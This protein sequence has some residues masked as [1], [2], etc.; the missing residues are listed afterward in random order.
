MN[1][2]M[3]LFL[4]TLHDARRP[5]SGTWLRRSGDGESEGPAGPEEFPVAEEPPP[6]GM[7]TV[8]RFQKAGP[9]VSRPSASREASFRA[10]AGRT[11]IP[12]GDPLSAAIQVEGPESSATDVNGDEGISVRSVNRGSELETGQPGHPGPSKKTAANVNSE[13]EVPR[14]AQSSE[15][16]D[17]VSFRET[18]KSRI[19]DGSER[20]VSQTGE[21]FPASRPS[22]RGASPSDSFVDAS[23]NP[24]AGVTTAR[25]AAP[26]SPR[27]LSTAAA[28]AGMGAEPGANAGPNAGPN[29]GTV[30]RVE[31][32]SPDAMLPPNPR[33]IP[34]PTPYGAPANPGGQTLPP[35]GPTLVAS[36]PASARAASA[37]SGEGP[38]P[39]TMG[40]GRS[41][42]RPAEQVPPSLV[43]G[44][45]EVVVLS[46]APAPAET[47]SAPA[48]PDRGFTSRNYL[49]RL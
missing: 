33:G 44:R 6:S 8:F 16:F 5:V 20:T 14:S 32:R 37:G 7:S 13:T 39:A 49:R 23:T 47:T 4:D 30:A 27:V 2:A 31:A 36:R 24:P 21:A 41:P 25:R 19:P 10:D 28:G 1:P 11:R 18:H 9:A 22:G 29:A 15:S 40:P 3:G 12:S 35:A 38:D 46:S 17:S 34:S 48:S 43:I 26:V 42:G 45:I